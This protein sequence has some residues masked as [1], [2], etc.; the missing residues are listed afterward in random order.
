MTP[1]QRHNAA[2]ARRIAERFKNAPHV[3][4]PRVDLPGQLEMPDT[5]R[6]P[7][8]KRLAAA[9]MRPDKPQKAC[10]VGLFGDGGAQ[11]DL[12]EMARKP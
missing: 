9:P 4:G 6:T 2:V 10:D 5:P 3:P 8:A 7:N 12:V 11:L 1:Y